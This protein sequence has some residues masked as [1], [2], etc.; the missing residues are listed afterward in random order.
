MSTLTYK[1]P[2]FLWQKPS[3]VNPF[4]IR[5]KLED[6]FWQQPRLKFQLAGLFVKRE[7]LYVNVTVSH[8]VIK[9][10][11]PSTPAL[12]RKPHVVRLRRYFVCV[13]QFCAVINIKPTS[14]HV[15]ITI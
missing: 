5:M 10:R 15:R 6:G 3:L 12:C 14:L 13:S 2:P 4:V 1:M 7:P 11:S 8:G 9:T